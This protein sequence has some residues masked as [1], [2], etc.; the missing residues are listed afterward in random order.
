MPDI[1]FQLP[2]S[3]ANKVI[4]E[5]MDMAKSISVDELD[6]TKSYARQPTLK[7]ADEIFDMA[8]QDACSFWYFCIRY[9]LTNENKSLKTD[10]GLSTGMKIVYFLW[11]DVDVEKA[12]KLA[13]KYKLKRL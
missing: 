3:K 6:C 2:K 13:K 11:I 7:T 12:Y 1:F 10:I 9:S 5:A 4:Q 8:K